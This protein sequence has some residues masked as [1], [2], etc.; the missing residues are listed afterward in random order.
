ML[1]ER[2]AGISLPGWKLAELR[3]M[4]SIPALPPGGRRE[5][6]EGLTPGCWPLG[7]FLNEYGSGA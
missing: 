1:Q 3:I 4:A 5:L 6:L 2:E 7:G